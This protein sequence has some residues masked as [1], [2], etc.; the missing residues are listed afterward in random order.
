M[1]G[2]ALHHDLGRPTKESM[3]VENHGRSVGL[4]AVN[5]E[6]IGCASLFQDDVGK[7]LGTEH[8][9]EAGEGD[10]GGDQKYR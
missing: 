2:A 9:G 4:I 6:L 5:Y 1:G 7:L 8:W 10:V 3:R